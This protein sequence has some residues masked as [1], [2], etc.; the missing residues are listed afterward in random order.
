LAVITREDNIS[1]GLRFM[2]EIR[3]PLAFDREASKVRRFVAAC[4]LYTRMRIR[5]K[6]V[7]E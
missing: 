7:K 3:K 1:P 6:S 5:K 4:K 2:G